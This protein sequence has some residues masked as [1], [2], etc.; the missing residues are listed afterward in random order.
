MRSWYTAGRF[1][2]SLSLCPNINS[3]GLLIKGKKQLRSPSPRRMPVLQRRHD[4]D[5]GRGVQVQRAVAVL[6]GPGH[7]VGALGPAVPEELQ[8]GALPRGVGRARRQQEEEADLDAE[9]Y[10]PA[11]PLCAG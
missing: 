1:S 9:G 8:E 5:G 7:R 10:R 3:G 11:V 6:Q 4:P 2:L